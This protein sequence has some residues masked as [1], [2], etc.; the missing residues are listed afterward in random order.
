MFGGP[1]GLCEG[2]LVSDFGSM[3][4]VWRSDGRGVRPEDEAS[5][6]AA[7]RAVQGESRRDRFGPYDDFEFRIGGYSRLGGVEG[8]F[9]GLTAYFVGDEG[10]DP[11]VI[12]ARERPRTEQ[13]ADELQRALG[14]EYEV[15]PYTDHW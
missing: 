6:R 10:L 13:F 3:V 4:K 2:L 14:D 11:E 8:L 1:E 7:I 15:A 9:V 5:L 12:L